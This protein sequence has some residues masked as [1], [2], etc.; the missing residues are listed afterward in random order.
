MNTEFIR[1]Y[2][3]NQ[4]TQM[5]GQSAAEAGSSLLVLADYLLEQLEQEPDAFTNADEK[6]LHRLFLQC[7]KLSRRLTGFAEQYGAN[8][9]ERSRKALDTVQSGD[10]QLEAIRQ[11]CVQY[12]QQIQETQAV[13]EQLRSANAE[14]LAKQSELERQ[15]QELEALRGQVAML[16]ELSALIDAAG[17]EWDELRAVV[18]ANQRIADA[19]ERSGYVADDRTNPDSFHVRVE[20]LSR[21]AQEV[22]E[23]YNALIGA[24][25]E[26]ARALQR[27]VQRRQEP[28]GAL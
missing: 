22:S 26:D 17:D 20:E 19:I 15:Q 18:D 5:Q 16:T 24:V 10:A 14:L 11:E 4:F 21:Q 13:Q 23:D 12:E 6:T 27:Q 9:A 1:Q 8:T 25:L 28:G 2:A 7:G 3:D